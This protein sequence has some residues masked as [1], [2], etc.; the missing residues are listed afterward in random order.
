MACAY[1]P[2]YPLCVITRSIDTAVKTLRG[3][4]TEEDKEDKEDI[5]ELKLIEI[6]GECQY[7]IENAISTINISYIL[8]LQ[9][10]PCLKLLSG[11]DME[12]IK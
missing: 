5:K 12:I 6:L 9:V 7:C 3:Q 1:T 11:E 10:N 4:A 8:Y 2:L